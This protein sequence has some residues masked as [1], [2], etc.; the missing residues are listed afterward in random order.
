MSNP[1]FQVIFSLTITLL[2]IQSSPSESSKLNPIN[3]IC[4]HI[5]SW[6]RFGAAPLLFGHRTLGHTGCWDFLVMKHSSKPTCIKSSQHKTK[7]PFTPP[8]LSAPP[9]WERHGMTSIS[10][11]SKSLDEVLQYIR[12]NVFKCAH[13]YTVYP[14]DACRHPVKCEAL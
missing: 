11:G 10:I 1:L 5:T 3:H 4:T 14:K 12:R 2:S 6:C 13:R 7:C 9:M 8:F